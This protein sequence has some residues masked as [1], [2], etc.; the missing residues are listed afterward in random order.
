M[1]FWEKGVGHLL[2]ANS[3]LCEKCMHEEYNGITAKI[4]A[5]ISNVQ[6]VKI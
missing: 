1:E 3:S 5:S 6:N 4:R 2:F